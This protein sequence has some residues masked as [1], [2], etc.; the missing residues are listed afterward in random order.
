M[1]I[2]QSGDVDEEVEAVS[3]WRVTSSQDTELVGNTLVLG[4]IS[5][6]LKFMSI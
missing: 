4:L 1:Y 3:K 2:P 5:R 6:C